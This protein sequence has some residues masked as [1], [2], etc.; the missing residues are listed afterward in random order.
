MSDFVVRIDTVR[1]S[2]KQAAAIAGAIQGGAVRAGQT[3]NGIGAARRNCTVANGN[4]GRQQGKTAICSGRRH[5]NRAHAFSRR[6]SQAGRLAQRH[7]IGPPTQ[8]RLL[9]RQISFKG[10]A[11]GAMRGYARLSD[12]A[13]NWHSS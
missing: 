1:L 2:E 13:E 7:R 10:M 5:K 3:W 9:Q 11:R 8:K 4:F 12:A 6:V